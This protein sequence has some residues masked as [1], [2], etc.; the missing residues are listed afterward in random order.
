MNASTSSSRAGGF[1][2]VVSGA[3]MDRQDEA[4]RLEQEGTAND[5]SGVVPDIGAYI[6]NLWNTFRNNR[7]QGQD[8][9]NMRLLRAQRM[10]EGKYDPEKLAQINR[11]G[12]SLVYSRIGA[13]KCRAATAMLRQIYLGPERPWGIE[14]QPDPPVP[15]DVMASIAKLVSVEVANAQQG[16]QP[17]T[18]DAVQMRRIGLE[19]AAQQAARRSAGDQATSA[20][21]QIEDILV[22]GGFYEA[23]T[24][25][26]TD[27]PI[28]PFAV[29]K[30]PTV[31]MVAKLVWQGPKPVMQR[32]PQM[33]WER[34]SPFDIYWS[35]GASNIEKADILERKRFTRNDL[36]NLLG[37]PGYDDDAI[38]G[39][40][41]DYSKGFREW[42]DAPDT[43]QALNEGR[44]DPN[45]N[46]SQYID[47][48]EFNGWIQ[49]AD[50]LTYGMR[51]SMIPDLDKDYLVQSWV[52]GRYTIKTQINPSP[53]QR[54][55]Y[56]MT[57]YEKVPGTVHGHSVLDLIE[58]FQEVCNATLRA[59]VNNMAISSG[60][61]VVI[62]DEVVSPGDDSDELYPWKRWHVATDP[63]GNGSSKPIEFFQPQSNVQE[64]MSAYQQVS[65]IADDTSAIPRF[66][67]G[68]AA[69]GAGRT[70]S[71]LSQ[72]QGNG[73]VLMQ[74]VASNVDLDVM[75]PMLEA[76]YDLIMLT[77]QSGMLTG[78]EQVRVRGVNVA[79]QRDT[80][81]QKQLQFLQ[82]TG[83][84]IDAPII[85]VPGRAK[86]LRAVA[87]G[88][89]LPDDVVPTDQDI[90][91]EQDAQKQLA[92]QQ[93]Q[94]PG[95]P[96][97]GAHTPPKGGPPGQPP[98][99]AGATD[100]NTSPSPA[101]QAQGMQAPAAPPGG[102]SDSAPPSNQYAPQPGVVN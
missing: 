64:L 56:F 86:V 24:Q 48:L 98:P 78:N 42:L 28:F 70:A 99:P 52:I 27:L 67:T 61:Q 93:G 59:M 1:L 31:R 87:Q 14:P 45:W 3:E 54:H 84:P 41:Q 57:S 10:F 85:G 76:L 4:A 97:A 72:L 46:Q 44:E 13:S 73:Q 101:A 21:D 95:G 34:V 25:F 83:N 71:G 23:L 9:L 75:E 49:G 65:G 5:R 43:E 40:L 36:S 94:P 15:P 12:G 16:G 39:V 53:R 100:I 58:D 91:A 69:G 18:G 38:R 68:S 33:F 79:V 96:P 55:P 80:E 20:S 74:T 17:L 19:R 66:M 29:L 2:R 88:L 82:I 92:A 8:P 26:L 22:A 89:G 62:N 77:D 6:R 30:G 37:L 90:Q 47:G 32:V 11:F 102:L 50:L 7:N 35:P 51:A 63:M 81:R 60:P